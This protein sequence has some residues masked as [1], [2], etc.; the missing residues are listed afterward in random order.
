[1]GK[2]ASATVTYFSVQQQQQ[3]EAS[4]ATSTVSKIYF[5]N[6]LLYTDEFR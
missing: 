5:E 4:F 1:L 6:V 2:F 3:A